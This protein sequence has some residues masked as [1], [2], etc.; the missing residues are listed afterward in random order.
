M[1]SRARM[2]RF[3]LFP[4]VLLFLLLT[5]R[6]WPDTQT[7]VQAVHYNP[8]TQADP[9]RPDTQAEPYRPD[10]QAD[11]SAPYRPAD[12][13]ATYTP[14]TS[15]ENPQLQVMAG[16]MEAMHAEIKSLRRSVF[17]MAELKAFERRL[18]AMEARQ[19]AALEDLSSRQNQTAA[20]QEE[21]FADFCRTRRM[22]MS[23]GE[24][25]DS[26]FTAS[27]YYDH[28]FVP[29]NARFNINRCWIPR[30]PTAEWLKID[31]GQETLVYGVITQGRPDY[32]QWTMTYKLSFSMDG[33]TWATYAGTDGSDKVFQGNYDRSSPVYNFLHT[34]VTTRHVQF[35]PLA[36]Q[37]YPA[38]RMEVL[39]CPTELLD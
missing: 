10:T 23:T 33:Q 20:R 36:Y 31:L 28:R 4:A 26:S 39:G 35:H 30:T 18:A 29:V 19:A 3:P 24:I 1:H 9:Y 15:T 5:T 2:S 8:D 17:H 37:N 25:P 6:Q 38:V 34:P 7:A 22:G 27:S 32:G 21:R 11:Q 13:T 14:Y 12:Q 16:M